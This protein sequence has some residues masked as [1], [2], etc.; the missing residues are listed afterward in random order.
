MSE[1]LEDGQWDQMAKNRDNGGQR[2]QEVQPEVK[3]SLQTV[4]KIWGFLLK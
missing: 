1:K 2:G 4:V 3:K